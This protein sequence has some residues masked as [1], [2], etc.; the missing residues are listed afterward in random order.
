MNLIFQLFFC[1]IYGV[2]PLALTGQPCLKVNGPAIIGF[3]V[4]LQLPNHG[5]TLA[6]VVVHGIH[7]HN[8]KAPL[9]SRFHNRIP[10][11]GFGSPSYA[12][13]NLSPLVTDQL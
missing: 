4:P 7:E 12:A 11:I 13:D 6:H 2:Q 10:E 9:A 8:G 3:H 1:Y 5:G